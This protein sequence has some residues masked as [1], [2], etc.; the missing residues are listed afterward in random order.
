[1]AWKD[2]YLDSKGEL[3][4]L[5]PI[6]FT[7]SETMKYIRDLP[8][9]RNSKRDDFGLVIKEQKGT[10]SSKHAL[11]KL[12]A[13]ENL[14]PNVDLVLCIYKMNAMNTPGISEVLVNNNLE[15]IP[16]AHCILRIEDEKVDVTT[17]SS[18]YGQIQ[19]LILLEE[20]IKPYQT[21]TYKVEFHKNYIKEWLQSEYAPKKSFEEI[22]NIRE[23]CISVLSKENGK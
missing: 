15:Y 18:N 10:C 8:Y 11:L 1:M 7:W 17:S 19:E 3:T 14:I 12:L 6:K 13:D 20:I 5:L 21:I 23:S 9:G 22:W 4:Q 16:E 2:Q